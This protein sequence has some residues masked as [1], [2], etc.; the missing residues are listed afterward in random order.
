VVGMGAS[1]PIGD[2][3]TAAGRTENRRVEVEATG[4]G[5]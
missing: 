5:K 1:K 2:N 3:K 4:V